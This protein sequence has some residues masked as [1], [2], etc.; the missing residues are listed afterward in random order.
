M[1]KTKLLI[2]W[3]LLYNFLHDE[4]ASLETSKYFQIT[5]SNYIP[6]NTIRLTYTRDIYVSSTYDII[7]KFL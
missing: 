4:E 1:R 3:P 6:I 5:C 7:G 2:Y